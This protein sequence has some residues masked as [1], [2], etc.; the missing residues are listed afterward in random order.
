MFFFVWHQS[1]NLPGSLWSSIC[2]PVHHGLEL[3]ENIPN[4]TFSAWFCASLPMHTMPDQLNHTGIKVTKRQTAYCRCLCG[5]GLNLVNLHEI[6]SNQKSPH[7]LSE[8]M[9]IDSLFNGVMKTQHYNTTAMLFSLF[10]VMFHRWVNYIF[11]SMSYE[12]NKL[13][14]YMLPFVLHYN[15]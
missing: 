3:P 1:N 15:C 9:I 2:Y 8:A 4:D 11:T 12:I 7:N 5:N 10:Y 13:M 14:I 6:Q